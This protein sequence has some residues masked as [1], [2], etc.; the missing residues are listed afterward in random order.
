MTPLQTPSWASQEAV[1]EECAPADGGR[2]ARDVQA[3][4][5]QEVRQGRHHGY[6]GNPTHTG[7]SLQG[8]L[9]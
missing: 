1:E 8:K 3:V 2:E 6:Q 4:A 7:R 9:I 5:Q